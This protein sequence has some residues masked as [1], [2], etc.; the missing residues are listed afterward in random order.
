MPRALTGLTGV[1]SAV[2]LTLMLALTLTLVF[3]S[4]MLSAP[5]CRPP[6]GRTLHI[7]AQVWCDR[8]LINPLRRSAEAGLGDILEGYERNGRVGAVIIPGL[9]QNS[10]LPRQTL[11]AQHDGVA[12]GRIDLD[13]PG[14]AAT[15][16]CRDQR[17]ARPAKDIEDVF[18]AP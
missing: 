4:P 8:L 2:T 11:P 5:R 15:D 18:A 6:A 9:H 17:R 7:L 1:V 14:P 3:M 10:A 13:Q 12:I 16:L